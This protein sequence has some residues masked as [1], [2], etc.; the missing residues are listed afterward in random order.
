[1]PFIYIF[2]IRWNYINLKGRLIRCT[3]MYSSMI[4]VAVV[5]RSTFRFLLPVCD[6]CVEFI[7]LLATDGTRG[8]SDREAVL[9]NFRSTGTLFFLW[10]C[11]KLTGLQTLDLEA[12]GWSFFMV[13]RFWPTIMKLLLFGGINGIL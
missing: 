13:S 6:D 9:T 2:V 7:D 5:G 8:R 10:P 1:M 4:S 11:D 3:L 12:G